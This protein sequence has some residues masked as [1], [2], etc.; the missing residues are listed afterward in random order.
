MF[1]LELLHNSISIA[2]SFSRYLHAVQL[3]YIAVWV[4]LL[5]NITK[6][7]HTLKPGFILNEN[8]TKLSKSNAIA[9]ESTLSRFQERRSGKIDQNLKRP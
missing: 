8:G 3:A 2:R 5:L 9:R 4:D 1:K 7:F 6:T